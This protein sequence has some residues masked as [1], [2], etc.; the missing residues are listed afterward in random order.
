MFEEIIQTSISEE[1]R[2]ELRLYVLRFGER[3]IQ[4][5]SSDLEIGVAYLR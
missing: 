3:I 2:N 1:Y 5:C 4:L